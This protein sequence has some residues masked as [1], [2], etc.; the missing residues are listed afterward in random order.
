MSTLLVIQAYSKDK[1]AQ[2]DRL[3]QHFITNYHQAHPKDR[4]IFHDLINDGTL[5]LNSQMLMALQKKQHQKPLSSFEQKLLC[6]HDNLLDDF[7]L[8]DKYLFVAPI[9]QRFLP[10]ELKQYLDLIVATLTKL[11]PHK[12]ALHLQSTDRT[13]HP[14][15]LK[16]FWDTYKHKHNLGNKYLQKL[17]SFHGLKDFTTLHIEGLANCCT[18]CDL[19]L[20]HCQKQLTKIANTF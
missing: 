10:A 18:S 5:T 1:S 20:K 14:R 2:L 12:K 7:M 4:I 11:A 15:S 8:A 9:Q 3:N 13:Y 6:E 17:L 19:S 16:Y